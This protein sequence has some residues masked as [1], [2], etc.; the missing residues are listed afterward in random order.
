MRERAISVKSVDGGSRRFLTFP[1]KIYGD[2][3]NWVPALLPEIK[4]RFSSKHGAIAGRGEVA[5]FLAYRGPTRVGRIAVAEDRALNERTGRRDC[6]FGFFESIDDFAVADALFQAASTWARAR[7]LTRLY[8]PFHFDYEDAYGLLTEGRDRPPTLLCGHTPAYYE[9][10]F[11]KAGFEPA[12][13]ENIAIEVEIDENRA[14]LEWLAELGRRALRSSSGRPASAD[15][16]STGEAAPADS[17]SSESPSSDIRVREADFSDPEAEVDRLHLLL[18]ESLAHL[19]DAMGWE[20]SS[21]RELVYS[22]KP[23]ADPRYVL[24]L[25]VDGKTV[26][27]FAAVGNFNE[28][29]I[30]VN[31]LRYPWDYLRLAAHRNDRLQCL[32]AKSI[33]VLPTKWH[34]RATIALIGEMARRVLESPYRW[35][36]LSLTSV[37][38]P[39]TPRLAAR[40]GGRI[41]K[42]YQIY[43]RTVSS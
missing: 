18:N 8:G 3:P 33:L 13:P 20:R 38:N 4:K 41:Y 42:R 10:L 19:S 23:I 12:R 36:D 34:S 2:D 37:D 27:W 16:S 25:E 21:V 32:A 26:G 17:A 29:L 14:R 31:G 30:K 9:H 15:D 7:R 39:E 35:V 11:E 28:V 1:W 22:L 6:V 43:E 5:A 24:F 40:V